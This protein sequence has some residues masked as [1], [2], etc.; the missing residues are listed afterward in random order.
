ME[1]TGHS[2]TQ[3]T[4]GKVYGT[5]RTQQDIQNLGKVHIGWNG[6]GRFGISYD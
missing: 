4:W 1:L 2:R 3:R 6:H 5:D